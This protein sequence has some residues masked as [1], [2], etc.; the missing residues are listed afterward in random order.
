MFVFLRFK[1]STSS[2]QTWKQM[3][4]LGIGI[5]NTSQDLDV[6]TDELNSDELILRS[7]TTRT[8]MQ[9]LNICDNRTNVM[10]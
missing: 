2:S 7:T 3:K 5:Q 9:Y 8:W 10:F 1:N 4:V 6:Y